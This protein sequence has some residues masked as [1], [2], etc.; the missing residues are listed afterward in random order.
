[1]VGM[2]LCFLP[3]IQ[4]C[5]KFEWAGTGVRKRCRLSQVRLAAIHYIALLQKMLT[6]EMDRFLHWANDDNEPDPMLKAGI[7]HLWFIMIHPFDDGNGR[8]GRAV[9]DYMLAGS[10][11]TLMQIVSFSKHI[12]LRQKRLLI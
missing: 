4:G 5:K 3:V 10:Y 1:M 12:K 2:Q 6:K 8:V 11:P 9:T 7:A